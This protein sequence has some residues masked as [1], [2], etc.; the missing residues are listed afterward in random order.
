MCAVCYKLRVLCP[1]KLSGLSESL[2]GEVRRRVDAGELSGAGLARKTLLSQS[3]V[4]NWLLGRRALSLDACECVMA[5]LRLDVI[6]VLKGQLVDG[7]AAPLSKPRPKVV[8][9]AP[10]Y[11]V[12]DRR[13]PAPCARLLGVA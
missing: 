6:E 10:R 4:C 5:A 2:A 7:L 9:I 8:V 1:I 11:R 3:T 12:G 13:E